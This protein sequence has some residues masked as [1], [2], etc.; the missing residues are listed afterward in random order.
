MFGKNA[1]RKFRYNLNAIIENEKG[2]FSG[3]E[4][5]ARKKFC[6]IFLLRKIEKLLSIVPV[7]EHL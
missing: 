6:D 7:V 3:I 1:A 2:Q 4:I 5:L